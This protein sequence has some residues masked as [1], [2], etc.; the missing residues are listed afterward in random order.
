EHKPFDSRWPAGYV[1]RSEET[2]AY[3][4]NVKYPADFDL[5]RLQDRSEE[6]IYNSMGLGVDVQPLAGEELRTDR[7][8]VNMGPQHPST[9][10]VF[11]MV[12]TLDG[13]TIDTLEP[14]MGYLH[15]NHEQIGE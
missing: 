2:N 7:L 3:G 9:H 10:G 5:S 6:T 1:R 14:V 11:R 8:V 12:M 15:R 4:H 13:E